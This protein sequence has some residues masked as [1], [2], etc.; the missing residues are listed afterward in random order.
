MVNTYAVQSGGC[1]F[2][3]L[4]GFGFCLKGAHYEVD[5]S[6]KKNFL[7]WIAMHIDFVMCK[8]LPMW[9]KEPSIET[10]GTLAKIFHIFIYSCLLL[11]VLKSCCL[12]LL[13]TNLFKFLMVFFVRVPSRVSRE[14]I[15]CKTN[16]NL[17]TSVLLLCALPASCATR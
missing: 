16:I 10:L 2:E 11:K 5:Y 8:K 3:S 9:H 14:W 17:F 15:S 13:R 12:F 7:S 1:R 4:R 6:G